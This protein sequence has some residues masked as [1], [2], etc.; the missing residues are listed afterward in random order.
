MMN[1]IIG[2]ITDEL[3]TISN[4]IIM[5]ADDGGVLF[6]FQES[7]DVRC[8]LVVNDSYI[9]LNVFHDEYHI[10]K[11]IPLLE[12]VGMRDVVADITATY[13]YNLPSVELS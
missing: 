7:Y 9:I 12:Y 3:R 1:D 2:A 5:G 4:V 13:C 8:F 11:A 6:E 10:K